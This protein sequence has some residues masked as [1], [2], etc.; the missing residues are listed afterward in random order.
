MRG[1]RHRVVLLA[2]SLALTIPS[3]AQAAD[4]G[5]TKFASPTGADSAVGSAAE[6]F[7]TAQRLADSLAA[8]QTGCLR[9]GSYTGGLSIGKGGVSETQRVTIRAYSGEKATLAGRV[10]VRKGANFVTV[11]QLHLDGRNAENLPSPT[12]NANDVTFRRNDVTNFHTAICFVLGASNVDN[13][14]ANGRAARTVIALNRIHNCGKLP[15]TNHHHGIYVE[16]TDHARITGNWIYDNAD[17]GIQLYPDAQHT[18]VTDNVIDGNGTGIIFSGDQGISS[19]DSVVEHNVITN[20]RLRF[21]VESWYPSGTPAGRN[22]ILR[23]NCVHGSARKDYGPGGIATADGGFTATSNTVADPLYVDRSAK[24]FTLRPESACAALVGAEQT[25]GP[26]AEPGPVAPPPAIDP[27]P[28][29]SKPAPRKKPKRV[30]RARKVTLSATTATRSSARRRPRRIELVGRVIATDSRR[31]VR[32]QVRTARGWRN[33]ARLTTRGRRAFHV[34]LPRRRSWQ[35]FRAVAPGL[36]VS[37]VV[38]L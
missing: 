27:P 13:S 5:C 20:A 22:N 21:N 12:V 38:R 25:P 11:E 8:G 34:S 14:V 7:R 2:A 17:R 30:S 36:G 6:P 15:A 9:A 28:R 19:H 23:S 35:R 37:R 33:V 18:T 4:P 3:A 24:D 31:T 10:V 1:M 29:G 32:I 26:G 16:G